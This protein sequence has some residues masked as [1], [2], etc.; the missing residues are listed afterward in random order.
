MGS[1][2]VELDPEAAPTTVANFLQY[3]NDGFYDGTIFHRV[4]DKFMIQGGGFTPQFQQKPTRP[5][6]PNE[7]DNRIKNRRGTIA[8]ARTSDPH[9]ATAQFFINTSENTP[10]N[11]RSK[12][13]R[14]WGYCVFGVVIRGMDVVMKINNTR[15]GSG[16][17][18]PKDVPLTAVVINKAFLISEQESE[19]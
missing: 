4:I 7:A 3:V 17:P 12:T 9:S 11:H 16:G 2:T 6:I 18:F 19:S 5:M 8:M 1:I 15:T 14:G 10:L 13:E